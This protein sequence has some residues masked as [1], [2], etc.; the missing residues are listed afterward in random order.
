M[1][2]PFSS[3]LG[4]GAAGGEV[5]ERMSGSPSMLD[6]KGPAGENF[7]GLEGYKDEDGEYRWEDETEKQDRKN[8]ER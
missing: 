5:G 1:V 7:R 2:V 4:A 3:G 6:L 8:L